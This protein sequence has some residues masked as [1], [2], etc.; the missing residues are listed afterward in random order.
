MKSIDEIK[1]KINIDFNEMLSSSNTLLEMADGI[2]REMNE[3]SLLQTTSPSFKKCAAILFGEAYGRFL[4]IRMLCENGMS[5]C[6]L[7]ILR[8][9]MNLFFIFHWIC[10]DPVKRNERSERYL[11]WSWK[12]WQDLINEAPDN[13]DTEFIAEVKNNLSKVEELYKFKRKNKL[14]KAKHWHEPITIYQMARDAGLSEHYEQGY[15]ALSWI[16]HLDPIATLPRAKTGIL[17]FDPDYDPDSDKKYF[18]QGLLLNLS[19]FRNI[20]QS[21]TEIFNLSTQDDFDKFSEVIKN[22]ERHP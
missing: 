19:Y 8:S 22:F 6:A 12:L 2:M 3:D 15:K 16:D 4:S 14:V 10:D 5:R 1:R 20:C 9:L 17:K 11:G 7:V 21:M 13:Y 18:F